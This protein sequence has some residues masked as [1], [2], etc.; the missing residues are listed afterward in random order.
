MHVLVCLSACVQVCLCVCT[1]V[2][3]LRLPSPP[4]LL[5]LVYPSPLAARASTYRECG[6]ALSSEPDV[7]QQRGDDRP[8][9]AQGLPRKRSPAS[10]QTPAHAAVHA[11]SA[12][13]GGEQ[14]AERQRDGGRGQPERGG[15]GGAGRVGSLQEALPLRVRTP[16]A[17]AAAKEATHFK[18]FQPR[19][20][21]E[22]RR[23]GPE[24]SQPFRLWIQFCSPR[25]SPLTPS[26]CKTQRR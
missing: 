3:N 25:F 23:G 12:D 2:L 19:S 1:C 14:P 15:G 17:K 18:G 11:A 13:R 21:T 16:L 5:S 4:F 9:R 26:G 10:T 8:R 20:T 7:A 6:D 22:R 24:W